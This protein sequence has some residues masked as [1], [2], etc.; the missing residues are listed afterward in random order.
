[1]LS[2]RLRVF[3]CRG[4]LAVGWLV[5]VACVGCFRW[6]AGAGNPTGRLSGCRGIPGAPADVFC[7]RSRYNPLPPA[8][9]HSRTISSPGFGVF[10]PVARPQGIN[11]ADSYGVNP[12]NRLAPGIVQP[13]FLRG[14]RDT[15]PSNAGADHSFAAALCRPPRQSNRPRRAKSWHS[16]TTLVS[17]DHF[18]LFAA[19]GAE[20]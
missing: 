11:S 5:W 3:L 12:F 14:F 19:A 9:A 10:A 8:T 2:R 6:P 18:P 13:K 20:G 16:A 17:K 1:M 15:R 7:R 4:R